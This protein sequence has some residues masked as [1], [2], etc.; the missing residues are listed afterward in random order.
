M[1]DTDI[2]DL[3]KKLAPILLELLTLLLLLLDLLE[4]SLTLLDPLCL[5]LLVI[6]V[7]FLQQRIRVAFVSPA[8]NQSSFCF[9]SPSM[10]L[11][12]G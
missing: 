2:G 1:L 11:L 12:Q 7:Y 5:G 8:K 10:Y 4:E 6:S 3:I 9:S